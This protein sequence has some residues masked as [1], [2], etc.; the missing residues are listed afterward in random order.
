MAQRLTGIVDLSW[1][2]SWMG[3][4]T[5]AMAI[6]VIVWQIVH[7]MTDAR[8]SQRHGVVLYCFDSKSYWFSL[9]TKLSSILVRVSIVVVVLAVLLCLIIAPDPP[10]LIVLFSW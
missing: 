5:G 2:A 9:G 8:I 10:S 1:N 3:I 4:A 7:I 6:T